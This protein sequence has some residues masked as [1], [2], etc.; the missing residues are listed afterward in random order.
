MIKYAFLSVNGDKFDES[1]IEAAIN[2][3]A[4]DYKRLLNTD[5]YLL[6]A[7]IDQV[8]Q[9]EQNSEQIRHFLYHMI[10][11]EYN[12]FWREPHPAIRR[13]PAFKEALNDISSRTV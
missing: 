9:A 12:N 4:V 2:N 5:D 1:A 3:L 10:V 7:E 8:H 13:L 6:L 11:L